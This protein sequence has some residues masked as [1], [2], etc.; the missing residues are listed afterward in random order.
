MF[1]WSTHEEVRKSHLRDLLSHVDLD[2]CTAEAFSFI[3]TKYSDI[4]HEFKDIEGEL[5]QA[6]TNALNRKQVFQ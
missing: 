6:R 4:L 2:Y 3:I 1:L 5:Y